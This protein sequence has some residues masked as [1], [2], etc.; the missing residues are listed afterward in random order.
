MDGSAASSASATLSRTISTKSNTRRNRCGRLLPAAVE[1]A[2]VYVAPHPRLREARLFETLS[3]QS[4]PQDEACSSAFSPLGPP[5]EGA[6][7]VLREARS[8]SS[9]RDEGS[10]FTRS[11]LFPVRP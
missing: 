8:P 2:R 5:K 4:V 3:R 6:L 10:L 1:N 7:R 11:A 9:W